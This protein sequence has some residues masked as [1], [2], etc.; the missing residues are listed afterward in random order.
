M[1]FKARHAGD[2]SAHHIT[3]LTTLFCSWKL[4]C[5]CYNSCTTVPPSLQLAQA[6]LE[7]RGALGRLVGSPLSDG[8]WRLASLGSVFG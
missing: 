2:I 8:D 5:E 1:F 3:H 6:D 7:I 4:I